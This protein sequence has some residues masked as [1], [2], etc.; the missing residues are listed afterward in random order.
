MVPVQL[1]R[2]D[3]FL[4]SGGD[5]AHFI[6][7]IHVANATGKKIKMLHHKYNHP[8]IYNQAKKY[9]KYICK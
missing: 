1:I 8:L 3:C 4:N 5:Q 2:D 7:P 9:R 6:Y